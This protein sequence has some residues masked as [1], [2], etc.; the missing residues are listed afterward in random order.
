[1]S[2]CITEITLPMKTLSMSGRLCM[3]VIISPLGVK[4]LYIYAKVHQKCVASSE[5][6]DND[7]K[8][9]LKYT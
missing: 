3:L 8:L 5:I 9:V 6:S 4:T 1:M 2:I 7:L